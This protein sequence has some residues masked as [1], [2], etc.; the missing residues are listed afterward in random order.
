MATVIR[1]LFGAWGYVMRAAPIL[2]AGLLAIASY[3]TA[4][5]AGIRLWDDSPTGSVNTPD[6]FVQD[7]SWLRTRDSGRMQL[8]LQGRMLTH[9]PVDDLLR[10]EPVTLTRRRAGAA[11]L[12]VKAGAAQMNNQSGE[13]ALEKGVSIHRAAFEASP[14][15]DLRSPRMMLDTD[16]EILHAYDQA[17]LKRG[18]Q[19]LEAREIRIDQLSG[20]LT[21]TQQVSLVLPPNRTAKAP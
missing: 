4:L 7:F 1:A 12:H 11:A 14:P 5:K 6:Y 10:L 9:L 17:T 3:F 2:L 20:Q 13:V 16:H 19:V 8:T 15:F 21:A 18:E